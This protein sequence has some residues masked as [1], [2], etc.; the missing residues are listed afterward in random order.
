MI[1][2]YK[3]IPFECPCGYNVLKQT[4]TIMWEM[5]LDVAKIFTEHKILYY[6][7]FGTLLGAVRHK[8]FIPWDYDLDISVMAEDYDRA[9][10][11]LREKYSDIYISLMI[12]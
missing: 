11:L 10:A 3:T 4:Q 6:L 9:I 1:E 2:N 12:P 5:Y 8:G 7:S